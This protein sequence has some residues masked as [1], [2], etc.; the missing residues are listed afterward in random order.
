MPSLVNIGYKGVGGANTHFVTCFGSTLCVCVYFA[1]RPGHIPLDRLWRTMA[2]RTCFP[3]FTTSKDRQRID[4]V[5]RRVNKS[6]LWTSAVPSDF[7]TFEDLCSTADDELF[8]KTSTFSNHIILLHAFLPPGS[9][10][11]QRY[12]LRRRTNSF[13][14]PGHSIRLSDCN[15]LTRMLHQ[16]SY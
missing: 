2:H 3:Y 6:G 9:T 14:L 5:L 8:T 13:Q 16:N 11:S 4:A 7:L 12:S 15:F 10:A 1:S